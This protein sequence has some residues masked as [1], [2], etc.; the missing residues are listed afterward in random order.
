MGPTESE[1]VD[2]NN[3]SQFIYLKWLNP[4]SGRVYIHVHVVA[5]EV[6]NS[7]GKNFGD[8]DKNHT[9]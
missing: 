9:R 7:I 2:S 8:Q 4:Q 5:K 6:E 3:Q 1:M